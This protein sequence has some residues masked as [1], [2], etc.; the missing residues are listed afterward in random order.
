MR[1]LTLSWGRDLDPRWEEGLS[2]SIE[3]HEEPSGQRLLS[4]SGPIVIAVFE[5]QGLATMRLRGER[6]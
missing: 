6:E 3:V 4:A 5:E 2:L 1:T